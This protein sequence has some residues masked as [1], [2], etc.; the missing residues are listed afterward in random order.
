MTSAEK[1]I[2]EV[3]AEVTFPTFYVPQPI[4]RL[5]HTESNDEREKYSCRIPRSCI[6]EDIERDL[7][8][9]GSKDHRTVSSL[10]PPLVTLDCGR[11]ARMKALF[12]EAEMR[13]VARDRLFHGA[14]CVLEL[15]LYQAHNR[16]WRGPVVGLESVR[17]SLE[18]LKNNLR[19]ICEREK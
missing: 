2:F 11:Y 9:L 13:N 12:D 3:N 19:S 14:N 18:E 10:Y 5:P 6:P 7:F 16:H 1:V 17:V 15:C 4:F 8:P